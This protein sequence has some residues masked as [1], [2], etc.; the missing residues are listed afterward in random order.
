TNPTVCLLAPDEGELHDG[1]GEGLAGTDL[2]LDGGA[3]LDSRREERQGDAVAQRRAEVAARGGAGGGAVD[4]HGLVGPGR[5]AALGGDASQLA[6]DAPLLLGLERGPA[7][8]VA[9]VPPHDPAQP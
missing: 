3:V 2:D 5:A 6:G 4:E 7:P 1:P 9:L 8:E